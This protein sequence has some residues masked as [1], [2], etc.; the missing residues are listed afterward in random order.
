[1]K[2]KTSILLATSLALAAGAQA[3]TIAWTTSG[4]TGA[5]DVRATTVSE[6]TVLAN[7]PLADAATTVNGVTFSTATIGAGGVSMA[8]TR[9]NNGAGGIAAGQ[10]NGV[11]SI[12]G[13][14]AYATLLN[15]TN[16]SWANG[17]TGVTNPTLTFSFTNLT[18]GQ[19][20]EIRVWAL[21]YTNFGGGRYET[22][23]GTSTQISHSNG[24]GT[25]TGGGYFKGVFT[26]DSSSQSFYLTGLATT[27]SP[28]RVAQYNALQL[29]AIPEPG[30]ALL[31]GLGIL[32][33]LRRRR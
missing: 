27:P 20:Y 25:N 18:L 3:A 28:D 29:S 11:T 7:V 26:A 10:V 4:L 21:N 22:V 9:S 13:S 30:S 16:W 12:G 31:G 6:T 5:T 33:L 2:L 23:D 17:T 8:V 24:N 15:T 1:M 32:A 14:T 19:K